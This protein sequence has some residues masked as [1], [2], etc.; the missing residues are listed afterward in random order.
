[1]QEPAEPPFQPSG[2]RAQRRVSAAVHREC[3]AVPRE[4]QDRRFPSGSARTCSRS[5]QAGR[6]VLS[7]SG[8]PTPQCACSRPC[9]RPDRRGHP[10]GL[11]RRHASDHD[12]IGTADFEVER[13]PVSGLSGYRIQADRLRGSALHRERNKHAPRGEAA[14]LSPFPDG[15]CP[16]SAELRAVRWR[17]PA[18]RY[19]CPA[20]SES[21]RQCLPA[22]LPFGAWC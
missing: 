6:W 21:A 1:M 4:E 8:C 18:I 2:R 14:G 7:L 10:P 22:L 9:S 16:P 5:W 12:G 15:C 19:I 3:A 13:N 11:L 20:S 17:A